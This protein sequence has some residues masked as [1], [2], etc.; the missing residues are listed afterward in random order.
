MYSY[1]FS[2]ERTVGYRSQLCKANTNLFQASPSRTTHHGDKKNRM[3]KNVVPSQQ[4]F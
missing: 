2:I 1:E 3:W 4:R